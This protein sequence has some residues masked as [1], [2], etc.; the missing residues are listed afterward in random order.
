MEVWATEDKFEH[1]ITPGSVHG[2][3]EKIQIT[4][5]K[6]T[7]MVEYKTQSGLKE[8]PEIENIFWKLWLR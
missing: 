8:F 7:W 4:L 5:R 6:T 3:D 1:L 2:S